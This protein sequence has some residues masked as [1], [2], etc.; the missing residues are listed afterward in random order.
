MR[1]PLLVERRR[2]PAPRDAADLVADAVEERLTEVALEGAFV[3]RLELVEP[4]QDLHERVLDEVVGVERAAG[5]GGEAAVR[6][7]LQP[8]EV[9]DE[10]LVDGGLVAPVGAADEDQGRLGLDGHAACR[11]SPW[12]A[13]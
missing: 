10:E 2:R 11:D 12:V 13:L 3:A 9:A 6:P 5:P 4:L 7:P 1:R 8:R